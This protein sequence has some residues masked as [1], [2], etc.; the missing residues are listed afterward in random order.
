MDDILKVIMNHF[1]VSSL[2]L[3]LSLQCSRLLDEGVYED[4]FEE[5]TEE[6]KDI[7]QDHYDSLKVW[8]QGLWTNLKTFFF[9]FFFLPLCPDSQTDS[10]IFSSFFNSPFSYRIATL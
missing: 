1:A 10:P 5:L 3:S 6:Y 2:A 9:S 8:F 4:F 7:R